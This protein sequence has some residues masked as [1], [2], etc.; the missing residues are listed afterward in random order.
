LSVFTERRPP[1]HCLA[2]VVQTAIYY[3]WIKLEG[4]TSPVLLPVRERITA[5]VQGQK[6]LW[7]A[8]MSWT[9]YEEFRAEHKVKF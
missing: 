4:L 7:Y 3:D 2:Q 5:K 9:D 6:N 1:E 8:N